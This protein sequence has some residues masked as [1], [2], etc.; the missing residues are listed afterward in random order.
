MDEHEQLIAAIDALQAQRAVLG[1]DTANTALGPLRERLAQ[2]SAPVPGALPEQ[3]RK[4]VS[5]LFL[6]VVG[7]VALSRHLDAE[8]MHL[9]MDGMLARCAQVVQAHGGKVLQYAGDSLLAAFGAEQAQE[10][11]AERA[12]RCGLALL[13]EGRALGERV[14]REHGQANCDV[15][16]GIHTGPVLLGGGV[17]E[18]GTIR[19]LT[20]NIAARMEQTAPAGGLRISQACWQWVRGLFDAQ[21]QPPLMVKGQDR[22]LAT[23]LVQRARPR[24]F[25]SPQRGIDG[26]LTPLTGRQAELALLLQTVDEARV[27]RRARL[28]T[29]VA[30]PGLGKSRLLQEVQGSLAQRAGHTLLLARAH[31]QSLMQPYGLLRDLV[32]TLV[33][34]VDSD[35]REAAMARLREGLAP[36]FGER[37]AAHSEIL[38]QLIGLP[39]GDSP[40]LRGVDPRQL[41]SLGFGALRQALRGLAQRDGTT[42]VLMLEDLQWADEGSLDF[43]DPLHGG[44][45]DWPLA[46]LMTAR[47]A[48]L[49]RRASWGSVP[50]LHQQLQLGPL[51]AESS[52]TLAAALVA[53]LPPDGADRQALQSLLIEQAEGNPFYMEELLKM[54]L[55]QGV[56]QVEPG[57][58]GEVWH[59]MPQRWPRPQL[60]STLVGVLQARLDALSAVDRQALQQASIIGHVFWDD[61][62][63]ALDAQAP[64]A[65]PT[66]Q[67]KAMV[68]AHG[69][70]AFEGTDER[71]FHHHLL[72]QVTY[73]TVLRAA[74]RQG[75]AR[76]AQWLAE[77]VGERSAEYL[78]IT[79]EH[80]RRADDTT[81]AVDFFE[82]AALDAQRRFANDAALTYV[83]RALQIP[84]FT[85]PRRRADFWRIQEE[86][87]DIAGR[88]D[89][90]E[91]AVDGC[92]A[93][94]EAL[95]DDTLRAR[96]LSGRARLQSRRGDESASLQLSHAALDLAERCGADAIAAVVNGQIA[97]SLYLRGE[98][99]P[100]RSHVEAGLAQ[101]ARVLLASDMPAHRAQEL[102]LLNYLTIVELGANRLPQ[103]LA[104][105]RH[106]LARAQASGTRRVQAAM[107]NTLSGVEMA[108]A[109]FEE[110]WQHAQDTATL[111][112]DVNWPLVESFARHNCGVALRMMGR[113]DEARA[114]NDAAAVIAERIGL[115]QHHGRCL[116]LRGV[117]CAET[118]DW[119]GALHNYDQALAR[120]A[121]DDTPYR[122]Q[123]QARIA[124]AQLGQGRLAQALEGAQAVAAMLADG[125][126]LDGIEEPLF[127]RLACAQIWAAAG[128]PRAR[129]QAAA[130]YEQSQRELALIE[131][132]Q[133]RQRVLDR[134]PTHRDIAAT[135]AAL[136]DA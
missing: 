75:H 122:C 127:A 17:D 133:D 46:L 47:P 84:D 60:P 132:P 114:T 98:I 36:L 37:A 40:H 71:N 33:G 77:R 120:F 69:P 100:M 83:E 102:H 92:A 124:V 53:R 18:E 104:A 51:A 62:L 90:C 10:D 21:P 5:V 99:V 11:D 88:L 23:W 130:A 135:W 80:Y 73:E 6:D 72:H 4:Q 116:L 2:L 93:V 30:D 76:A 97:H 131:D 9:V 64:A 56:I 7:S 87:A 44:P 66:L 85:D 22:P 50:A 118:G 89:L 115:G 59:L 31:P 32:L 79:A 45:E 12:V 103:A 67:R 24:A 121:P 65:M 52:Q 101:I 29:L 129:A 16:V 123:V 117:I 15:R 105:G 39:F 3:L 48:L 49:E 95:S 13:I 57:P 91:A 63:G 61:A 14:L 94:A 34:V 136:A 111:A 128:D 106:A 38:G 28:L 119:D 81:R 74:R 134:M 68:Q 42:L 109:Q 78:A 108:L 25:Q 43:F 126:S 26:L 125:V 82:Q 19:G 35:S 8:D 58:A 41:R 112:H 110:G 55:D 1:D 86:V 113:H 27:Q 96:V 20:V 70:S 54:L 107:L